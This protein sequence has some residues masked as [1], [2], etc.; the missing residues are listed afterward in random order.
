MGLLSPAVTAV[1]ESEWA[2][3]V[4]VE[5]AFLG[6]NQRLA[7]ASVRRIDNMVFNENHE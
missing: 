6:I 4:E 7:L 1:E 3:M 5:D 2:S